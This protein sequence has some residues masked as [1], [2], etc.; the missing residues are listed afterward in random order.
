MPL[1]RLEPSAVRII[2][3]KKVKGYLEGHKTDH[4]DALAIANAAIQI[5]VKYSRPKSLEQQSMH[6]LETSRRFLS[7][8]VVSL[9]LHI[10][11]TILGYGIANPRGEKGL[12]A[13]VQTVLDGE[14]AETADRNHRNTH[15]S[16][17]RIRFVYVVGAI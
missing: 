7:R 11:G 2:N 1:W 16:Q 10:Q 4:N 14:T 13:S 5:G 6:S 17:C 12:K 9:A 3:P 15:T 8:S